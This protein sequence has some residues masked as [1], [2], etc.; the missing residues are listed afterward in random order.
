MISQLSF[1]NL[2]ISLMSI[3]KTNSSKKDLLK[4]LS[5]SENHS[6]VK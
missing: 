6:T 2:K 4:Y 3:T 1:Y 5:F